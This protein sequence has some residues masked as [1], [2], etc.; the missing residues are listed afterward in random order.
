MR[1][2]KSSVGDWLQR[3]GW[4]LLYQPRH[5]K[6]FRIVED[7][8]DTKNVSDDEIVFVG[9]RTKP[10]WAILKCPCG[11]GERLNVD[12]MKTHYPHWSARLEKDGSVSFRPSLWVDESRCGSHFF[13]RR[14]RIVWCQEVWREH[15]GG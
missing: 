13:V 8:S 5:Y 14:G 11:C 1:K 4:R 7:M 3:M 6:H 10:K 12:L 15:D 9:S 2:K